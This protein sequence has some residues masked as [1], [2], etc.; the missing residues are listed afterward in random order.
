[1]R[2]TDRIVRRLRRYADFRTMGEDREPRRRAPATADLVYY[3]VSAVVAVVLSVI[4]WGLFR[5]P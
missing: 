5:A 1:M 2:G 3:I 4:F